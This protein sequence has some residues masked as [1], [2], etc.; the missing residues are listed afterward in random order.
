MSLALIMTTPTKDNLLEQ[1]ASTSGDTDAWDAVA[2]TQPVEDVVT[3]DDV[4]PGNADPKLSALLRKINTISPDKLVARVSALE[5]PPEE[6]VDEMFVPEEPKSFRQ[7]G[8]TESE[9]EALVLKLQLARGEIAGRSIAE[10]LRLPFGLVSGLLTRMKSD[11]LVAYRDSAPM[12]DYVYQ[13]TEVGRERARRLS[14]HCSYFGAAPV[15][16]SDYF[17]SVKA[18]TLTEQHPTVD[19]LRRAFSD[20]LVNAKM[21]ERLG[22]AVNS[23]R[24]LF[25]FG[26]P[27]N[28]KTSIAE[29]VT[30]AFGEH[31]WIPRAIGIDGEVMRL[32]DPM[33]HEEAPLPTN[34]TL[35]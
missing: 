32:F 3:A 6:S 18:Q 20:L 23:G 26:A 4:E 17:S 29:R 33:N 15:A 16:L 19:D 30:K 21:L 34:S 11:Q 12:N 8:L 13:L 24:G 35:R 27:G 1:L 9:L 14:D 22:P 31:I 5:P 2:A 28:G 25:L 7:A 10:F